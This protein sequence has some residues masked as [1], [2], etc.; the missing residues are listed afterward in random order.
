MSNSAW[1]DPIFGQ[2]AEIAKYDD[3]RIEIIEKGRHLKRKLTSAKAKQEDAAEALTAHQ[4]ARAALRKQEL[5]FQ[6][7]ERVATQ[8][9]SAAMRALEAG[10]GSAAAAQRQIDSCNSTIDEMETGQLEIFEQQEEAEVLEAKLVSALE[11]ATHA[12]DALSADLEPRL[13]DLRAKLKAV[14]GERKPLVEAL[15]R[16]ER[17]AYEQLIKLK[18]TALSKINGDACSSCRHVLPLQRLNDVRDG[19]RV[20]CAGCARWLYTPRT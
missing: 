17:G 15:P 9:R 19:A 10:A 2:L 5:E 7:R 1:R 14:T 11:D 18:K 3:R 13:T 12:H 4:A 6:E 16:S 20:V 8:H